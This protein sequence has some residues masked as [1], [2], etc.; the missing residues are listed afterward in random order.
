MSTYYLY[1]NIHVNLLVFV[2]IYLKYFIKC[3]CIIILKAI[4]LRNKIIAKNKNRFDI[5]LDLREKMGK[6][7]MIDDLFKILEEIKQ[8]C[9]VN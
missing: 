4:Y 6:I 3:K 8:I 7:K 2:V 9:L 1:K 5:H